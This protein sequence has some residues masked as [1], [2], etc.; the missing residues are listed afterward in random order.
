[1]KIKPLNDRVLV[2]FAEAEDK[3][4]GGLLL[5]ESSQK[6]PDFCT[7]IETGA[8]VE[9]KELTV[10]TQIMVVGYA[11]TEINVDGVKYTIVKEQDIIA[12][13]NE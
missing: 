1:M 11:G 13:I 9:N 12:I 3:T 5:I 2:K 4:K 8:N 7:I 6:K 10:G